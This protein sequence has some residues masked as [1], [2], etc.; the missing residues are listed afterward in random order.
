[1]TLDDVYTQLTHGELR[2][3]FLGSGDIDGNDDAMPEINYKKVFPSVQLGLTELY[4]RFFLR[5]G[6]LDVLLDDSRVTYPL[7]QKHAESNTR[8][9]EP[10]FILDSDAPFTND[11]FK[12]ERVYGIY[13]GQEY[14]VPLNEIGNPAAVRTISYN[15]LTVPTDVRHAPWRKETQV[16]HIVYRANHPEI[17][18]YRA[19]ASPLSVE[20]ELP[21]MYL[22][23]LCFYIA[24]RMHNPLG[25]APDTMHE[26]NN[27]FQRFMAAVQELKDQNYEI[28][29]DAVN[30]KLYARG[31]V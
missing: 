19:N 7:V 4:K 28:D 29:D 22:E 13:K 24:S 21:P 16:L 27:Y 30:D 12:I 17:S 15:T 31:F 5:E 3:L 26:G 9:T 23:A 2:Q 8:S 10:K 14:E 25:M 20:I 6:H 1:M 11:L 18:P